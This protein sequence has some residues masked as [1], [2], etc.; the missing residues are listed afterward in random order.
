MLAQEHS[1]TSVAAAEAVG[2][3]AATL[4]GLVLSY[5]RIRG[6]E[7]ATDEEIAIALDM[8]PS[9]ARP[10]RV[11]LERAGLIKKS[12]HRPNRSGRL[13]TVWSA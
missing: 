12:G 4:R 3:S 11:E 10:R 5:I 7:G 8:N 1:E 6:E 2:S 13:A 9:T